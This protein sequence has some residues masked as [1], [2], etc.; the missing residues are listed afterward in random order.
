MTTRVPIAPPGTRP[1]VL[2]TQRIVELYGCDPD[3]L[4]R[5]PR[6]ERA[7]LDAARGAGA[8]IVSH[9]FHQ[10]LPWGVSG[11]VVI[12]ESHLT[13]HTWPEHGY[14]AVDFFFCSEDVDADAAV[15]I[16]RARFRAAN[17]TQHELRRGGQ[18][19]EDHNALAAS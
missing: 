13:V 7:L 15:E 5:A 9:S 17:V 3:T 14:A 4:E 1:L 8:R 19:L 16:L 18:A 10:F 11:V 12:E 2:G 6:V